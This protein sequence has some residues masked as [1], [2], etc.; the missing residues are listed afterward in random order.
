[1]WSEQSAFLDFAE[2]NLLETSQGLP[3]RDS[4]HLGIIEPVNLIDNSELVIHG[5]C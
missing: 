4:W 1:M 3:L 5:R 2:K